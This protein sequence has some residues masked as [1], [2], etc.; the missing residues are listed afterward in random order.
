[1]QLAAKCGSAS[2]CA[3]TNWPV[4]AT[5]NK[6]GAKAYPPLR[7]LHG[8][9]R[10]TASS[11][12]L[13]NWPSKSPALESDRFVDTSIRQVNDSPDLAVALRIFSCSMHLFP[14]RRTAPAM[15]RQP[16]M[17]LAILPSVSKEP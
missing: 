14:A 3:Y 17:T 11:L 7:G 13:E 12:R 4:D 9:K 8:A 10:A 16:E 5:R 15:L 1:M 2:P 6:R